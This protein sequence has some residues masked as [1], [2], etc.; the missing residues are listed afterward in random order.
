[1]CFTLGASIAEIVS[2]FPTC[3]GLY[4]ASA[5]LC[6]K[7]HR[8]RVGYVVGWLNILG[9]IAG[10]SS[11]EFG[12]AN[13]I[14]A[15]VVLVK[16]NYVVTSYKTVGLFIGASH[17]LPPRVFPRSFDMASIRLVV[18]PRPPQLARH[19]SSRASHLLLR[20]RQPRGKRDNHNRPASHNAAFRN[21]LRRIRVR[22]G[23]HS[24][25]DGRVE[26]R[27][28]V[29]VRT[30]V[31]S[32]SCYAV[33]LAQSNATSKSTEC[34]MDCKFPPLLSS[35][36]P[37]LLT[38]STDDR[39]PRPLHPPPSLTRLTHQDYDATAHISEEVRRAAYAAPVAIFVAVIGTGLL[40]WLLNIVLILCSGP[41]EALQAASPLAGS[42]FLQIMAI[43][44]GN[45]AAL[46]LWV[47]L[48]LSPRYLVKLTH[49][50]TVPRLPHSVLRRP[51]RAPSGLPHNIRIQPRPRTARPRRPQL[52]LQV[53]ADAA[54]R[55][56]G[57]HL[58]QRHPRPARPREPR[59]CERGV[60]ADRDGAGPLLHHPHFP[61]RAA[62]FPVPKFYDAHYLPGT[63]RRR[64]YRNH[65]EVDFRPGPFYLGDGLLG[66]A[67]N[68]NCILWTLFVFV[69]F[70]MPT[71]MPVT[72]NNMNY[73]SVITV[74]VIVLAGYVS[75]SIHS[76][77]ILLNANE[78]VFVFRVWYMVA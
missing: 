23:R 62:S 73:A 18:R 16:P 53:D 50:R 26:Y 36:C 12:L 21:A 77:C 59:R 56:L 63:H 54:A 67:F 39:T 8:A 33:K 27:N 4:T 28:R 37:P 64:Y 71:V 75:L 30:C 48:S 61:V 29:L 22:H 38:S 11:T 66:W 58:P 20:L 19:A 43:R 7:R 78:L 35:R 10:V 25:P 65:P 47:N 41:L 51:N 49:V 46:F 3:G 68:I 45:P 52:Q 34:P 15:A 74:G 32:S 69:I 13:M 57:V 60:R 6:P 72:A 24:E 14:W 44:M 70:S 1:M 40:G 17:S 76:M 5:Q 55:D 31:L 9:Q 42:A 2:A